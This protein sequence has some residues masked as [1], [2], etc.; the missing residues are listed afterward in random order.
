MIRD[1]GA[2]SIDVLVGRL[3]KRLGDTARD[4]QFIQT[5]RGEGNGNY[6][7][8]WG[9]QN[10]EQLCNNMKAK[11]T[12]SDPESDDKVTVITVG[13]DLSAGSTLDRLEACATSP[14]SEHFINVDGS[15]GSIADAFEQIGNAISNMVYLNK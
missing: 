1:F 15:G 3:R 4:Q 5:V 12:P 8:Y 2:G 14:S 11:I 7:Y 13:Y 9:D 10:L 6:W